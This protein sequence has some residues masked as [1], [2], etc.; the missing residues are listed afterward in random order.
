ML[1][2]CTINT[3]DKI[4]AVLNKHAPNIEPNGIKAVELESLEPAIMTVITSLAPL[5]KARRVT[6]ARVGEISKDI[7]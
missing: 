3:D 4:N 5:A 1:S 6:P 7:F 2:F